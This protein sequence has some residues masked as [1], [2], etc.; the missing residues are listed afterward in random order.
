MRHIAIG[1]SRPRRWSLF[2]WLVRQIEGGT[3]YSHTYLRWQSRAAQVHIVY[4][5]SG[6][7][8]K[9]YN[10]NL[11]HTKNHIVD[12]F[13]FELTPAQYHDLLKITMTNAGVKY[14]FLQVLGIALVRLFSLSKNPFADGRASQ[15]CSEIV[16]RFLEDVMDF[17]TKLDLD[18]AGPRDI[19]NYL[20]SRTV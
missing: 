19:Y 14:G 3:P 9:F 17:D 2:S 1:F 5:A 18:V 13:E 20:Q 11:W 6:T 15:V 12:E 8:L 10:F 7:S 4:E 16:G